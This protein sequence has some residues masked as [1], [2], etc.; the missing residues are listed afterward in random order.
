M[1][2]LVL[3]T[4]GSDSEGTRPE[5]PV[6]GGMAGGRVEG[7]LKKELERGG[8]YLSESVQSEQRQA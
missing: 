5:L 7:T 4:L 6:R 3:M 1:V 2:D 8:L